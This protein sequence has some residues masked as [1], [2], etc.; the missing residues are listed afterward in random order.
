M[1]VGKRDAVIVAEKRGVVTDSAGERAVEGEKSSK[2]ALDAIAPFFWGRIMQVINVVKQI[3][4]VV[5]VRVQALVQRGKL[6]NSQMGR[7][8]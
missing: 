1:G 5:I 4:R 2:R 3:H 6:V 8:G 7:G